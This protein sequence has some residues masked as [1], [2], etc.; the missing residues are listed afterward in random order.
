MEFW[1]NS[2]LMF[3]A[4]RK[5]TYFDV[6]HPKTNRLE[7]R[8][9][10]ND[11]IKYEKTVKGIISLKLKDRAEENGRNKLARKI[12]NPSLQPFHF[13]RENPTEYTAKRFSMV[14]M[15]ERDQTEAGFLN[16][17]SQRRD[18]EVLTFPISIPLID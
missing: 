2:E 5:K 16:R 17:R 4:T 11:K 1:W 6:F 8:L 9:P 12:C 18:T 3:L 13:L 15:Q 10:L 7:K 14:I